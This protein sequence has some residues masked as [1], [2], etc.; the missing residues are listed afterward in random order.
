MSAGVSEE[1]VG[2]DLS[3]SAI[4]QPAIVRTTQMG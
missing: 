2:E 1:L 3:Q 4:E